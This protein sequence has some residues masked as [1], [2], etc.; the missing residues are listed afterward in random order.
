MKKE[1]NGLPQLCTHNLLSTIRGEVP[2]ERI[3]GLPVE[4][5]DSPASD[6][7]ELV[8]EVEFLIETYERRVDVESASGIS[9]QII[10]G[11][12]DIDVSISLNTDNDEEII[13]YD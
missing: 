3:K 10:S 4:I 12:V 5:I 8:E 6:L 11:H 2:Y 9:E 13:D 7:E 1:G